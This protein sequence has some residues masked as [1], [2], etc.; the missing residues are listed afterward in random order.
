MDRN[1]AKQRELRRASASDDPFEQFDLWFNEAKEEIPVLPEGATLGTCGADGQPQARVVLLKE[2][3][4]RGFVFFTNYDS[5]KGREIA[6]NDRVVLNFWWG[7]LERQ[8]RIVGP[9]EKV[10]SEESQTYFRT[11]PRGSQIGAWASEQSAS[12]ESREVLEERAREL[13]ERYEDEEI[14]CPPH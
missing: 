5:A 9:V 8:V 14:P 12:V 11:R 3:D 10:S 2:F 13:E 7:P 6:E 4:E 1:E